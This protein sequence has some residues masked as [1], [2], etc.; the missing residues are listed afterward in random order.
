MSLKN[1][2]D[3]IEKLE[4]ERGMVGDPPILIIKFVFPGGTEPFTPEESV[5]LDSYRQKVKAE[6]L[7]E[8]EA[9]KVIFWTREK[10][11]EL[12]ALADK[13]TEVQPPIQLA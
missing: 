6:V 9:V 13:N 12:L 10:A 5:A 8:G 1:L 11:Q 7:A 3:R 2:Q 4:T